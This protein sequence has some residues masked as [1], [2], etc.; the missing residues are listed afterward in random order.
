MCTNLSR[1]EDSVRDAAGASVK[2]AISHTFT[3]DTRDDPF[4]ATRGF[5]LR[6]KQVSQ[7][8]LD[9]ERELLLIWRYSL[10]QEYAGLG[11]DA[12][13]V[14]AEQ[15]GSISRSLGGG[16]VRSL[17]PVSTIRESC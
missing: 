15:E 14:K 12:N 2:S 17:A 4:I 9:L 6:L 10:S 1:D 13:F 11:G 16:Y 5:Y 3:R 7:H 8:L